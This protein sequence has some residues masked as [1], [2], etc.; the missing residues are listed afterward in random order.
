MAGR[1]TLLNAH[2][3]VKGVLALVQGMRDE[4]LDQVKRGRT[5]TDQAEHA[6]EKLAGYVVADCAEL[7][8]RLTN[9]AGTLATLANVPNLT[10]GE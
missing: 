5:S 3:D 8:Y 2:A 10:W 7:E 6:R 1:E 4:V 9:L